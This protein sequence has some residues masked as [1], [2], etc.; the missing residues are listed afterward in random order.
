MG[1]PMTWAFDRMKHWYSGLPGAWRFGPTTTGW[2]QQRSGTEKR[3]EAEYAT[4]SPQ[5]PLRRH[6]ARIKLYVFAIVN[7]RL[8]GPN[9]T[10]PAAAY[11]QHHGARTAAKF[12]SRHRP[13]RYQHFSRQK[14][15]QLRFPQKHRAQ[16]RLRQR[17]NSTP[18]VAVSN[19]SL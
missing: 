2:P 9:S 6:Y 4:S 16:E 11:F 14:S 19:P 8:K 18:K 13:F 10:S 5:T 17:P 7:A 3:T 12:K 15:L 1:A